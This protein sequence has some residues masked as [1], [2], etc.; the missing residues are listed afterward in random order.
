[1]AAVATYFHVS[2]I[3]ICSDLPSLFYVLTS[4]KFSRL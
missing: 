1:M 4:G 3:Q 2:Q